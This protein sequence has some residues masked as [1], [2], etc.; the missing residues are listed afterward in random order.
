MI[1]GASSGIGE[2]T[3]RLLARRGWRCCSSR[4]ARRSPRPAAEP[5]SA[6]SRSATSPT[7]KRS[8]DDR[9]DSRTHPSVH[10][11]V[12]GAGILVRGDF[13][14]APLDLIERALVVNYLGGV[15]LTHGLL[16]GLRE[17]ARTSGRSHIATIASTAGAIV[18]TPAAPYSASKFAQVAFSRSLRA[19]LRGTGIEVHTI[20][21]GFV[22]TPG[23]PHPKIFSTPLGRPF[24][25]GP[26]RVAKKV[27][28]AVE[29]GKAELIVPWFPYGLGA[30]AQAV[31]PRTTARVLKQ[32]DYPRPR[33]TSP[34]RDAALPATAELAADASC[35]G[36]RRRRC[37]RGGVDHVKDATTA[38]E[39]KVVEQASVTSERLG[40]DPA[41]A[42]SDVTVGERREV[43]A[44]VRHCGAVDG[45]TPDLD[46]P[47]PPVPAGEMPRP[48]IPDQLP[49]VAQPNAGAAVPLAM[50][51]RHRVRAGPHLTIH[52]WG[53]VDAEEG[54]RRIRHRVDEPVHESP[55][56]GGELEVVAAERCNAISPLVE[57]RSVSAN[58]S[59]CT[60]VQTTTFSAAIAYTRSELHDAL[61]GAGLDTRHRAAEEHLATAAADVV[62]KGDRYPLVVDDPGLRVVDRPNAGNVRFDPLISSGPRSRSPESPLLRP[63]LASS[64]RR[65]ISVSSSA[66]TSF[67]GSPI[68]ECHALRRREMRSSRPSR[69]SSAFNE[70]GG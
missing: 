56:A 28:S 5:G 11:L 42:G 6:S 17:A 47:G 41:R 60:P 62:R 22:T 34:P 67:P 38:L 27:I 57:R 51:R 15:W 4:G 29:R 13:V 1:T 2:A 7:A 25:I 64:S 44:H 30:M 10:L 54:E 66:T 55:S 45:G 33:L 8:T 18:F 32:F 69:Q 58:R 9:P 21:P 3:A 50:K 39:Q 24:V 14:E 37:G 68:R 35:D 48:G 63:R 65:G 49:R 36:H 31:L 59:D 43:A 70:P 46:A 16:P 20:M 52:A 19:S 53:E 12:N 61:P 26:E 40:P 23:F